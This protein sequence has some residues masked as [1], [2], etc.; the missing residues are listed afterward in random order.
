MV[1]GASSADAIIYL[2]ILVTFKVKK[3]LLSLNISYKSK[4]ISGFLSISLKK[5]SKLL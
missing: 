3:R 5:I 4:Q 1:S 2:K